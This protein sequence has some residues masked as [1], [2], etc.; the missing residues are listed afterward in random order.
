MASSNIDFFE[1]SKTIFSAITAFTEARSGKEIRRLRPFSPEWEDYLEVVESVNL[2][3]SK[4]MQLPVLREGAHTVPCRRYVA[5]LT[6]KKN[7]AKYNIE[8]MAIR[9][10]R[11][12]AEVFQQEEKFPEDIPK[13]IEVSQMKFQLSQELIQGLLAQRGSDHYFELETIRQA[14]Y[15]KKAQLKRALEREENAVLDF[16]FQSAGRVLN[17]VVDCYPKQPTPFV[18]KTAYLMPDSVAK[19]RFGKDA[20]QLRYQ[21]WVKNLPQLGK[22]S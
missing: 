17:L 21:H 16:Y 15:K 22:P 14:L 4:W 10:Q 12:A 2:K 3:L 6:L 20:S 7:G 13:I 5:D 1:N 19:D 9:V 18:V 8:S 11:A